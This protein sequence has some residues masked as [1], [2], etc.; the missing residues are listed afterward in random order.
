M[1]LTVNGQVRDQPAGQTLRQLVE[2]MGMDKAVIAVEIN[3]RLVPRRD[4]E[5]TRLNDGDEVE[6]VTLV[7]GG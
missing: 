1:R 2:Q 6:V 4:H 7:G 5:A 3:R